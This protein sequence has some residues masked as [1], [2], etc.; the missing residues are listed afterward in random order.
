MEKQT[1]ATV[2]IPMNCLISMK[3]INTDTKTEKQHTEELRELKVESRK[4]KQKKSVEI[5]REK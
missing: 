1:N 2:A 3:R 5:K 4:D